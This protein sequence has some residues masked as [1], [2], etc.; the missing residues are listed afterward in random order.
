MAS[1]WTGLNPARVGVTDYQ[2]GTPEEAVL[3]AEILEG[4][5]GSLIPIP[6]RDDS[7]HRAQGSI[8]TG[9]T[10]KEGLGPDVIVTLVG[11]PAVIPT[12]A[13]VLR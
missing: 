7:R 9:T 2:H 11:V 3:P 13:R 1:L 4:V 12:V 10:V 6:D 5:G 8:G